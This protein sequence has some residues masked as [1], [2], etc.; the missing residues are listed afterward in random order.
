MVQGREHFRFALKPCKPIVV[1]GERGRQDLDGDL[2][3]QL[4]VGR[5]KHLAHAA[6]AECRDHFI[7]PETGAGGEGQVAG[8]FGVGPGTRAPP[9]ALA[10]AITRGGTL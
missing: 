10:D 7:G 9:P 4:G 8:L 2:A 3:F 6:F 1:S 5:A